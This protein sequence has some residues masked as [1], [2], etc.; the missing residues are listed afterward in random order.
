MALAEGGRATAYQVIPGGFLGILG[1][2]GTGVIHV[3]DF[4]APE[5]APPA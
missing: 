5:P 3:M 1:G 2:D 4:P